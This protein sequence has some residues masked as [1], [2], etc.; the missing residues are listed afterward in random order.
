MDSLLI[1][2]ILSVGYLYFYPLY[3][4][5]A[6]G[7]ENKCF[8]NAFGTHSNLILSMELSGKA[9]TLLYQVKAS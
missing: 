2:H 1:G 8:R 7:W 3:H 6:A 9:L 4:Q 5:G